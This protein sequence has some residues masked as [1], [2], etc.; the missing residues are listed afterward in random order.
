MS[1]C[2][3][4][5]SIWTYEHMDMWTFRHTDPRTCCRDEYNYI[6]INIYTTVYG[7][8][9]YIYAYITMYLKLL[10]GMLHIYIRKKWGICLSFWTFF[11]LRRY[12]TLYFLSVYV[13][14]H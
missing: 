12:V 11:H 5:Q 6:M 1:K 4:V 13:V 14:S 2:P 7:F 3:H 8:Y 10:P 9:D